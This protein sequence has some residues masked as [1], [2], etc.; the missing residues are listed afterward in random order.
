RF[1]LPRTGSPYDVTLALSSRFFTAAGDL[2][3][4]SAERTSIYGDTITVNGVIMPFMR[5]SKRRYKFRILNAA[6]SRTFRLRLT[7]DITGAAVPLLVVGADSGL[8]E[9]VV[10][11]NDIYV[12]MAERWEV[13][14]NFEPH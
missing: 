1:D 6:P 10:S 14:I 3:D 8:S 7:D 9:K 4:E 2:T 11:T 13:I 12:G 5:V